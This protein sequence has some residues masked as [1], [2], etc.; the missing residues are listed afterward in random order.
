[1]LPVSPSDASKV[2]QM[3]KSAMDNTHVRGIVE[4]EAQREVVGIGNIAGVPVKG[5]ADV[6]LEG[7]ALV[8]YKTTSRH[9]PED[10]IQ[11]VFRFRY[12]WQAAFYCELL[13]E[14]KF[15]I[16]AVRNF[17][18]YETMLYEIPQHLIE[19]AKVANKQALDDIAWCRAI[20]NWHSPGWAHGVNIDESISERRTR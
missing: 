9:T 15:Y 5:M 18:P 8:D 3:Y 19:S 7:H 6:W 2:F 11:D 1:M 16:V 14:S 13:G 4:Q 20:D 17:E 12:H 10:F